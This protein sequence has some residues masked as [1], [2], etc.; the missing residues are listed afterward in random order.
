MN[1]TKE[2]A[3]DRPQAGL[4]YE[5]EVLRE[6]AKHLSAKVVFF[7]SLSKLE[8]GFYLVISSLNPYKLP[9]ISFFHHLPLSLRLI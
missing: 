5:D 2:R 1:K 6:Q 3:E 9:V 4:N 8:E 7:S